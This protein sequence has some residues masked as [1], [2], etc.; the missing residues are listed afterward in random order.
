MTRTAEMPALPPHSSRALALVTVF[1]IVINLPTLG[2][3]RA[4][5]SLVTFALLV[6]GLRDLKALLVLLFTLMPVRAG[7][8]SLGGLGGF[9]LTFNRVCV[10][11]AL[12][13]YLWSRLKQPVQPRRREPIL[14]VIVVL[15]AIDA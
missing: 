7:A 2:L 13:C 15:V 8:L 1:L 11:V 9:E 3:L 10:I 14:R 4:G 5:L 12:L 6:T